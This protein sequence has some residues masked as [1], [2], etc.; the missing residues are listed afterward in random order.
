MIASI[1]VG[2]EW[3]IEAKGCDARFLR[4][5]ETLRGVFSDVISDLGLKTLGKDVWHKFDG[6]GGV[7]GL[8]A[9]TE[10]HLACHTYPEHKIATFNLYCCRT[11]PE[12]DWDGNLRE[13]LSAQ[14]VSVTKIKRGDRSATVPVAVENAS[15]VLTDFPKVQYGEITKRGRGKLPH[16]EKEN[17]IYFV[18]FRLADALPKKVTEGLKVEREEVLRIL[19]KTER[20]LS[21]T[22]KRKIDKLF[23]RKIEE[24]LDKGT[25]SC[26][27][28]NPEVAEIAASSL[29][30]FDGERYNIFSWSVMPN[31]VH[32]VFRPLQNS[33]LEGIL[34]SWKS[35]SAHEIN[36]VLN[37]TGKIWQREYYDRLIRNQDE[38]EKTN[39]YVLNNPLKAG[40]INWK[41]V[42][43]RASAG[44][45]RDSQRDAGATAKV[46]GE[47]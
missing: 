35:Y 12:W 33:S 6:E 3:L 22:E 7:T 46:G 38:F 36:R 30:H 39:R 34:H 8:V 9:L 1:I 28:R 5:E 29:R 16:W 31:H 27:L 4:D 13:K 25:G 17:G 20:E 47:A 44:R 41:W 26:I 11:R 21:S 23:T 43:G 42:G 37:H 45:T 2:T 15:R 32:V 19:E 10:S 14:S 40:L 18:T 24:Y